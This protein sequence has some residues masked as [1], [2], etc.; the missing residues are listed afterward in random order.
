M[1]QAAVMRDLFDRVAG[2]YDLANKVL[3]VGSDSGWRWAVAREVL[4]DNPRMILDMC[5]GTADQVL[6]I[7]ASK[8]FNGCVVGADISR[9][10]MLV[11]IGKLR[12]QG[13]DAPMVLSDAHGLGLGSGVFDCIT[14]CFGVRNFERIVDG[15]KEMGRVLRPQGKIVILEFTR[16]ANRF[17]WALYRQYLTKILPF[18]GGLVTGQRAAY[19]YLASSI[20]SFLTPAQL[21]ARLEEAGFSQVRHQF[22]S[23]GIVAI[24][25]AIKKEI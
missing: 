19:R 12:R 25:T 2:R 14:L 17:L 8:D 15:L 7:R 1:P 3:S 22:L 13:Y 11:G 4:R 21:A 6:A 16:P 5:S 20:D 9:E 24:T 10:M 23:A 18:I